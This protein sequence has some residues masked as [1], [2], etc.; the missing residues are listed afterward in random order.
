[1]KRTDATSSIRYGLTRVAIVQSRWYPEVT[2][3][4]A[5]G[6]KA[7]LEKAGTEPSRVDHF[8]VGGSFELPQA[9]QALALT[10]RYEAIIAVGCLIRGETPHFDH[11]AQ[12]VVSGLD[13][14]GRSTGVPVTLGVLTTE[15]LAQAQA[16]AGGTHG[17][18]GEDAALAAVELAVLFKETQGPRNHE[19]PRNSE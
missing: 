12:S 2:N 5:Q 17:N 13:E 15:S 9:A 14:V 7:A 4:L 8:T 11:I 19:T 6:A 18:K 3:A 10:D 1:M 16:R